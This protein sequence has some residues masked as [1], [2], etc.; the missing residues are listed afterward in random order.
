MKF[1]S[2]SYNNIKA[3]SV[4]VEKSSDYDLTFI[5]IFFTE[6][7]FSQGLLLDQKLLPSYSYSS[8]CADDVNINLSPTFF[9]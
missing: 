6:F 5:T 1:V 7:V 8:H 2:C 4:R 9:P 3:H